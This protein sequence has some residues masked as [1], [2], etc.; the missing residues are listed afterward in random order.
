MQQMLRQLRVLR[1][2]EDNGLNF[3]DV[4]VFYDESGE[5]THVS[6]V[7][8]PEPAPVEIVDQ[9]NESENSNDNLGVQMQES[10]TLEKEEVEAPKKKRLPPPKKKTTA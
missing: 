1:Y 2:I 4:E 5:L 6:R 3:D 7:S 9:V 8:S 10:V